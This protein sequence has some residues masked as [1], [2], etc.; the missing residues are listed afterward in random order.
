MDGAASAGCV[1]VARRER[2]DRAGEPIADARRRRDPVGAVGSRAENLAQRGDL[3]GEI[4]LLDRKARPGGVHQIGL[5]KVFPRPAQEGRQQQEPAIADRDGRALARERAGARIE[6]KRAEGELLSRTCGRIYKR[7]AKISALFGPPLRTAN[8]AIGSS[9]TLQLAHR[10]GDRRKPMRHADPIHPPRKPSRPRPS[11]TAYAPVFER[12]RPPE[13]VSLGEERR[14][15]KERLAGGFRIFAALGFSEGVAGHITARDPEFPETFWVNPFGMDFGHIRTSDLIR[16]DAHGEVIEG[17]G[18]LNVAGLRDPRADPCRASRCRR[19]GARPFALWQ[20]VVV[21]RA[22][23]R[24]DHPG[25]V[26]VLRGS[27]LS[28]TTR[29]S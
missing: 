29:K 27:C 10:G 13:A 1:F 28:S 21:G 22:A 6:H 23:P 4:A 2:L 15:R 14:R 3:H 9:S 7:F 25:R 18:P 19:R 11:R 26:R 16:V 5:G 24:S 12:L 8:A 17:S 20:G